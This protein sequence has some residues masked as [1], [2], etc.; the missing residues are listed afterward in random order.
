[1]ISGDTVNEA[2]SCG[3]LVTGYNQNFADIS[4]SHNIIA[5]A[6]TRSTVP[7]APSNSSSIVG[8]SA[9]IIY[10]VGARVSSRNCLR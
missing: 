2:A 1:M 7:G 6:T 4:G 8:G 10:G 9:N 5:S 3:N